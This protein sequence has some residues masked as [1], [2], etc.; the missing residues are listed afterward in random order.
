[1]VQVKHI[2]LASIAFKGLG[3]VLFVFGGSTGA[4]LLVSIFYFANTFSQTDSL[5][6]LLKESLYPVGYL[7]G[8]HTSHP[9][10]PHMISKWE[11][12][13]PVFTLLLKPVRIWLT[14]HCR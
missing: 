9:D 5:Y 1:M 10:T 6:S 11:I 13:G 3:G 12:L 8:L 14:C 2:V 4:Y 7:K